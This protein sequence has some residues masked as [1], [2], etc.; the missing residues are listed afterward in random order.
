MGI[1]MKRIGV[2]FG[3]GGARGFAHIGVLRALRKQEKMLPSIVAGTSVGSIVA[4][5]YAAGLR[6]D[7][8]E[9]NARKFDWF[10]DVISIFDTARHV[11]KRKQGGL[12]S[13][14]ALGHT[15]NELIGGKSFNDLDIDLAV[16]AT[17]VE[18]RQRVI[19]TSQKVASNIDHKELVRFLPEPVNG[20]PGCSTIIISDYDDI[21]MAVRAS[22]AVPGVFRPVKIR[23]MSLLD[24]G[25][26]DQVP[27]DIIRAMGAD[28]TIGVSLSLSFLP[29]K[30][31]NPVYAIGGMIG[32]LGVQ[33]LRK[34]LD[35][36]DIGFQISGIDRRS[37]I[38]PSQHDLIDIGEQNMNQ[39]LGGL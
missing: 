11:L 6:Q 24:G 19:F 31:S 29:E 1:R 26:V 39:Y 7:E 17:D 38:D 27:V 36:A 9:D 5:L 8:I 16:V 32:I 21:G 14:A 18:N 33:Q 35:L 15:I 13:N 3:G 30:I 22:C 37:I 28:K 4:A 2:A 12:V 23:G 25:V 34:S 20:K 10:H